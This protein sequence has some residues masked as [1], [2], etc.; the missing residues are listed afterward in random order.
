MSKFIYLAGNI[1]EGFRAIG[2]FKDFDEVCEVCDNVEGWVMELES[3]AKFKQKLLD[4]ALADGIKAEI[5]V[6]D[7]RNNDKS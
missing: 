3:I 1:S 2:P 6:H 7:E 4:A 5:D